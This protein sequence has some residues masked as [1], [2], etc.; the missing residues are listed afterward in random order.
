MMPRQSLAPLYKLS[1]HTLKSFR[2]I[3][4][5]SGTYLKKSHTISIECVTSFLNRYNR[6]EIAFV[7]KDNKGEALGL[8]DPGNL[9]H[10][11]PPVADMRKGGRIVDIK[12]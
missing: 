2:N 9:N 7:R 5:S 3:L 10:L 1:N 4:S 6:L 11:A 8:V 12:N